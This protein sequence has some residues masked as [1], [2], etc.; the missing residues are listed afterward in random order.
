MNRL[1]DIPGVIC[2]S[3]MTTVAILWMCNVG[4]AATAGHVPSPPPALKNV[5]YMMAV[6]DKRCAK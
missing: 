1:T 6:S 5:L 4:A 3:I 2:N